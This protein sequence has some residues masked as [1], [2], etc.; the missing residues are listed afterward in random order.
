MFS[1]HQ[2]DGRL[3]HKMEYENIKLKLGRFLELLPV[4]RR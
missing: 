4:N 1:G 3:P 2:K